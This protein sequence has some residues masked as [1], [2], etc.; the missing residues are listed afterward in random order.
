MAFKIAD[1]VAEGISSQKQKDKN[2]KHYFFL[3]FNSVHIPQS[4][5]I[6][7]AK[8]SLR[9]VPLKVTSCRGSS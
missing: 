9:K 6:T 1:F 4:L 7:D 3:S 5:E 8:T 2:C